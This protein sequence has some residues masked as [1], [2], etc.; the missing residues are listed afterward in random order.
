M[1]RHSEAI[2]AAIKHAVDIVALVGEYL[3]LHRSGSKTYKALCPFHDDHN[4]SLVLDSERQSYKCWACGA[5]GDIFDFVKEKERVDFPEAVRMLAERA[6]VALESP[7]TRTPSQGPSKTELLAVNAWAERL[8]AEALAQDPDAQAYVARRGLSP[9]SVARFHLGFAPETREWLVAQARRQ[10]Y[11]TAMLEHAGLVVRDPESDR[12]PRPRFRG[13]LIFP[14]HDLRGRVLGFGGRILPGT[15]QKLAEAGRGVAKYLNSPETALFQK[16]RTLYA[17]DLAR[18][19]AQDAGWVAVV[20]G[21]TDVIAA[22][23]VGLA[24]VVGTLGTALGDDHVLALRRL[25]DRAVLVFDGDEAG[26]AAADRALELFLGHEVDVRVL[27]LP[28]NLDPCDFLL[29]EGADAFRG[30]VEHA[31]DPL[32]F[33]IDRAENRFNF[34]SVEEARQAAEWVLAILARVPNR[35]RMGLDLKVA[36]ALDTL[37]RRLGVPVDDL[38]RRLRQLHRQA[39]PSPTRATGL[40]SPGA[41]AAA[42][43]PASPPIRPVELDPLDRELIEIVLAQPSAVDQLL[44]RGLAV[45]SLR[46]APLRAILLACYELH[47]EGEVPSFDRVTLRLEDPVVKTL[48]L[49]LVAP[50]EPQ[51]STERVQPAAWDVRLADALAQLAERERQDRIR[52]LEAAL[53]EMDQATSPEDYR[54]LRMEYLHFLNQRPDAKKKNAW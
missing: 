27:T 15:E 9:E 14:I 8:F 10:S 51:P 21:Y 44:A 16:R 7:A 42:T 24:N 46:D 33:A 6:G 12:G 3:P 50:I 30:L 20:E 23:Q 38:K 25:A 4:P 39:R 36:K 32:T 29:Q 17:A 28:A 1:P 45:S 34:S 47:A 41:D 18:T 54:A 48:A 11:S 22:H 35:N 53:K 19:A 37:A 52:Q 13:R 5:G 31:V 49:D 2:L 40:Q 26:Q 43:P